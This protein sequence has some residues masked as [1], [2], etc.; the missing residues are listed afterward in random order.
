[1]SYRS[2]QVIGQKSLSDMIVQNLS[3]PRKSTIGSFTGAIS[4]KL[5][6]KATRFKERFDPMNIARVLGGGLG[7]AVYGRMG[8]AGRPGLA[9]HP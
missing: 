4:D 2:A 1:M 7:A 6:A 8:P 3:D 5:K 9:G